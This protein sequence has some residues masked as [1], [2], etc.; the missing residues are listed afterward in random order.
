MAPS[1]ERGSPRPPLRAGLLLVT[2]AAAATACGEREAVPRPT[3]APAP[4]PAPA[5]AL[6]S[7]PLPQIPEA[8][9]PARAATPRP[10]D[11]DAL[12]PGLQ[13][14][15]ATREN[16]GRLWAGP[17]AGNGDRPVIVYLPPEPDPL[18][19]YR[20]VYHFHGTYS[21]NIE[22]RA[23]GLS[24]KRW[25]GWERLQQTLDAIDELQAR[26]PYNVALVY[27]VSAG[28]R[29]DPEQ[30]G[31]FNRAYDRMWMRADGPER[32]DSFDALH[33][34]VR[35]LLTRSFRIRASAI[36]P[37][38]LAEGHSAGGIALRNIARSGTDAVAEYLF[39]DASFDGWADGCY[40]ATRATATP[41]R[42]SVVITDGGIADP[43]A[44]HDPWCVE[45]EQQAAAWE[46]ARRRCEGARRRRPPTRQTR[47][48][49]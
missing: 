30:Q 33:D 42:V 9:P 31:F 3:T 46:P 26:R 15:V 19:E 24:K 28:K 1:R 22:R 41:A 18:A 45:L 23:P 14:F 43:F 5:P 35:G 17:M 44:R 48:G 32:T 39:L 36:V 6:V 4:A 11:P 49:A 16:R 10:V 29:K 7:P 27:P 13:D 21:E 47:A 40:A 12:P 8:E 25:V 20:L 37:G 34:E 38:V 2:L